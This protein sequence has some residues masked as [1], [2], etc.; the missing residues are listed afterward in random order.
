[1]SNQFIGEHLIPGEIGY[2]FSILSLVS[3]LLASFAFAKAFYANNLEHENSWSKFAKYAFG[4]EAIAVL[5]SFI[6]LFYIISNHLFEYK[7]AYSHSD[8]S[9]PLEYLLS[10]FWEGQEG[11]FLLWS[12]WHC[13]L[14]LFIIYR[15]KWRSNGVMMVLS[16]TQFLLATMVLGLTIFGSKWGSS[17]FIL[18][19]DEMNWPILS[20]PDYLQ[21]IKDGTGLNTT[22]QNYWMVIHPPVLFLGFA[23]TTVPFAFAVAGLLKKDNAWVDKVLSWA[24]F[25]AA[26]LGLG[27]MMGA[28]WAYESLNFGGYW[29]WD[30]VENASLVPWLVL[31]AGIHT[32]MIYRKTGSSIKASYLFMG[33]SF[34]L[35]VYSTFL[36]RSGILGDT[37]VHAFTDLGMNT[38]LLIFLLVL[39][40]PFFIIYFLRYRFMEEPQKEDQINSRE[41]WILVG[42]LVLVL[43]A[44]VI[45]AI[46]SIP[47]F[48]KLFGTNIA[49]PEDPAFAHNQIQVFVAIIIGILTG[50]GQFLRFKH[51]PKEQIWKQIKMPLLITA[52][53]S[54]L[55]FVLE[56]IAYTEK[57]LGYLGALY[58]GVVTAVFGIVGNLYYWFNTLKGKLKSAGASIGH[59][60]FGLVLLGIFISS[61][62]KTVLSW[63]TTGIEVLRVDP[64][65]KNNPTGNPKENITLFE[66]INTDMGKYMVEYVRDTFDNQGKRFF[67]LAFT[68]KKTKEKFLLYPDILKNNKGAEGFSANPA[69]KHYLTKDIFVYITSFQDHS[70]KDTTLFKPLQLKLGDSVFYGN[71]YIKLDQ[72][73][74]NPQTHRKLGTNELALNLK[75]VSKEGLMYQA[76][77]SI[78]LE[79][80][81][82]TAIPDTVKAQNLIL[83]FNRVIDQEKGILEIGVKESQNLTNLI[84]LKVYEFPYINIL[85]L[86]IIIMTIGFLLSM[87]KRIQTN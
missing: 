17:P 73:L 60:G 2:F 1:M 47:V 44:T 77:P 32:T 19:R 83:N 37:S 4:I 52:L 66:A 46:T 5:G 58:I 84:T 39:V 51:T 78:V 72:V 18:L 16:S 74:V 3:S 70:E 15:V 29:A 10:C 54:T 49:P 11:S 55:I 42:S 41:F 35:V 31:V 30:P 68:D 64:S 50:I 81:D 27:I 59:I 34:L 8:K 25:S 6:V 67:E 9:M 38:Q 12:F 79:G 85:W 14:G 45:L 13:V 82:M 26:S 61:A 65:Q 69:A 23:S 87:Y 40:I 53:I 86:G 22:L 71:G 7:Y 62:N 80:M 75:V 43:S 21:F 33:L 48:N 63:N 20:K 36:T 76:N 28:A 24:N 56:G 57:G